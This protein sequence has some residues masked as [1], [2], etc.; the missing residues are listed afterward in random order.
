[1]IYVAD[2]VQVTCNVALR[3]DFAEYSHR[4]LGGLQVAVEVSPVVEHRASQGDHVGGRA[5]VPGSEVEVFGLSDEGC[6]LVKLA[7]SLVRP[8]L[9]GK[10]LSDHQLRSL[11]SALFGGSGSGLKFALEVAQSLGC[12]SFGHVNTAITR[13][14]RQAPHLLD[15]DKS[16]LCLSGRRLHG[17]KTQSILQIVRKEIPERPVILRGFRPVACHGTV[18][19]FD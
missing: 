13:W 3:A 4:L 9:R 17:S 2:F 19:A 18:A 8:A 11:C 6:C 1:I 10:R 7:E 12:T 15:S 16:V 14:R 5:P